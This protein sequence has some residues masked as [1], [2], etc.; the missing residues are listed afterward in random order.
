MVGFKQ[1]ILEKKEINRYNQFLT[2]KQKKEL[3]TLCSFLCCKKIIHINATPSGGGVAEI[4]KGLIPLM[5]GLGLSVSWCVISAP[6]KFFKITKRIHNFLQGK[7]DHFSKDELAYY[8]FINKKLAQ[9]LKNID[10]DLGVVHD[11]QPAGVIK[12]F[13]SKPL[14]SRIHIDLSSPNKK[15]FDFFLPV[16]EKYEKVIFSL[17]EFVPQKFPQDKVN[18][19]PPAID[20]FSLKNKLISRKKAR[21]KLTEFGIKKNNFLL[22]WVSRF[23]I[24]KGPFFTLKT[25]EYL[26]KEIPNLSLIMAG[27]FLAQ[28]DPQA[29]KVF[30]KV[31]K[32]S[33][34]FKD[35]HLYSQLKELKNLS[36]NEFINFVQTGADIVLQPS[37]K[38]GFGLSCTES[39]WKKK[40]VVARGAA[41][42]TYQIKNKDNGFIV[43]TPQQAAEIIKKLLKDKKTR[44]VIGERAHKRVEKEFLL[45]RLLIDHLKLYKE[46]IKR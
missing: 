12:F 1:V 40:V 10:F 34:D 7:K 24:F 33:K 26:K 19:F 45:P 41:G 32:I 5:R 14:I 39:M 30:E 2:P 20:P 25:Y 3:K 46:V 15:V 13:H 9:K 4:L 18:I 31:K 17:R 42:L 35:V 8:F 37:S 16:F 27:I 28:D 38:E 43:K 21:E 22:V 29:K 11:P 6:Q 36:V 23:D 44:K